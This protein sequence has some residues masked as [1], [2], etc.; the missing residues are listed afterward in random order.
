MYL[1]DQYRMSYTAALARGQKQEPSPDNSTEYPYYSKLKELQI[2]WLEKGRDI[3]DLNTSE[4]SKLETIAA[5]SRGIAG[6]QARAILS[7]AFDTTYNFVN[8]ISMPDT[9]LKA[10][11]V[12]N[13]D[14]PENEVFWIKVGPNPANNNINFS[15]SIGE[16]EN[17]VLSL[18]SQTGVLIEKILLEKTSNIYHFDC[19]S[20]KPGIYY[21][22]RTVDSNTLT[23]KFVIVH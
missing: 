21:Y 16:K 20:L 12:K 5:S 17:A 6:A 15:Y 19:S 3:F 9:T 11:K 10:I 13:E 1:Q 23:G 2:H 7:F 14:N 18:F 4:I 8:C 22:S